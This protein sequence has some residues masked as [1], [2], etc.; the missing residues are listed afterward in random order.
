M[1]ISEKEQRC[2]LES[3]KTVNNSCDISFLAALNVFSLWLRLWVIAE[4]FFRTYVLPLIHVSRCEIL[5]FKHTRV[6]TINGVAT[7]GLLEI[8]NNNNNN[9]A[10]SFF[11]LHFNVYIDLDNCEKELE[12]EIKNKGVRPI[13]L[14]ERHANFIAVVKKIKW[15][16]LA[17]TKVK[18]SDSEKKVNRSNYNFSSIM[19]N[20]DVSGRLRCSRAK[21]RQKKCLHIKV[22]LVFVY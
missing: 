19:C 8:K 6:L 2:I 17:A 22:V 1:K 4:L 18:M 16:M 12:W 21:Q 9:K 7:P 14:E 3:S 15:E 10:D 13:S 20:Y 11:R 5:H